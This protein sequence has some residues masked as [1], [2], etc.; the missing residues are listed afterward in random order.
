MQKTVQLLGP[1]DHKGSLV[2]EFNSHTGLSVP[3]F[4]VAVVGGAEELLAGVVE[5]NVSN[6]FAVA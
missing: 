3:E 1:F 2:E 6:R 4:D 5:A